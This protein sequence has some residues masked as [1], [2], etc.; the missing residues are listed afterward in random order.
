MIH[1]VSPYRCTRCD[2]L[3]TGPPLKIGDEQLCVV[4]GKEWTIPTYPARTSLHEIQRDRAQEA[5]RKTPH[6]A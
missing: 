1:L 4:C 6:A 3:L 5:E 2:G